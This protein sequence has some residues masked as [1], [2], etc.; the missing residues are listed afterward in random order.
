MPYAPDPNRSHRRETARSLILR[1]R[2]RGVSVPKLAACAGYN[3][4]TIYAWLN[5]KRAAP[6]PIQ[7]VDILEAERMV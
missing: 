1:L 5:D 4:H 3:S 7:L 6:T 2:A